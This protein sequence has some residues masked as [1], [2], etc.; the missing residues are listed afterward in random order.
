MSDPATPNFLGS[1][2]PNIPGFNATGIYVQG[3]YAYLTSQNNTN[4]T[5]A[6]FDISN[7]LFPTYLAATSGVT[8]L[9][10]SVYVLGPYAYLSCF[11]VNDSLQQLV[12][13]NVSNPYN[14]FQV[15]RVDVGALTSNPG[16]NSV[17]VSGR[18]AYIVNDESSLLFIVDV[19]DPSSP[20]VVNG[21][22]TSIASGSYSVFV[23]GRYAY[24]GGISELQMWDVSV[25]T[26]PLLAGSTNVSGGGSNQAPVFVVGNN[27]YLTSL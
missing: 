7:P 14:S 4:L 10:Y 16:H 17:Y 13:I 9:F 12:I 5:F 15:N 22:G 24:I 25:P 18:Y 2:F 27:A 3:K 23:S 20:T 6:I 26:M 1:V 21:S 11:D 8:D 19:S